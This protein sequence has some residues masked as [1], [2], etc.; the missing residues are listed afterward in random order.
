L[1]LLFLAR[2]ALQQAPWDHC[3]CILIRPK[4]DRPSQTINKSN[5]P[6]KKR[7]GDFGWLP[8]EERKQPYR[9]TT[10]VGQVPAIRPKKA[11]VLSFCLKPGPLFIHTPSWCSE[12]SHL[13]FGAALDVNKD[14]PKTPYKPSWKGKI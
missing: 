4:P 13:I 7:I 12:A 10:E 11:A 2:D 9:P 14:K 3:D 5:K 1:A 6:R 8:S